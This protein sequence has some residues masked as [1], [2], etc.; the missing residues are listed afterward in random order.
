MARVRR[1]MP[2]LDA[3]A[4]VRLYASQVPAV[5]YED[6]CIFHGARGCTLDRSLRAN[7]CNIYYCKGLTAYLTNRRRDS[8]RVIFAGKGGE[9]RSSAVLM[10]RP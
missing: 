10:P 5:S 6:S 7:I 1:E 3:G 2:D 4:V 8:P 9:T